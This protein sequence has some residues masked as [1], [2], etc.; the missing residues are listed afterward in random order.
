[1]VIAD[2]LRSDRALFH[3]VQLDDPLVMRI[4]ELSRTEQDIQQQQTR[5][6]NQLRDLLWRY[7]PPLIKLSPGLDEGWLWDL[8][9]LAPTPEKARKRSR[10]E[11]ILCTFSIEN[12]RKCPRFN[13]A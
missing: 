8:L 2:S 1:M 3:R 4:R 12:V 13:A 10:I 11:K 7:F 6:S 5:V 9:E